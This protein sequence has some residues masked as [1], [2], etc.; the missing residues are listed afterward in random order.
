M[1]KRTVTKIA[2]KIVATHVLGTVITN[3][4]LANAPKTEKYKVAEIGGTVAAAVAVHQFEQN[5]DDMVDAWFDAREA[6]KP[7]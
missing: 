4:L 6:K 2:A 1:D 3:A 7:A 5:I